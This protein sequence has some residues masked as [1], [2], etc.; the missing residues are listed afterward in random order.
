VA[1]DFRGS[2]ARYFGEL[3]V[4][5]F[6]APRRIGNYDGHGAL[7]DGVRELAQALLGSFSLVGFPVS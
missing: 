1:D 5:V 6:D 3:S 7:F 2:V 4:Y